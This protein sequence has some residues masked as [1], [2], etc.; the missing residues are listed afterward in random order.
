[1]NKVYIITWEG[2]DSESGFW[3]EYPCYGFGFFLTE[4]SVREK[5]KQL[6]K[7]EPG[8]YDEQAEETEKYKY[9][10]INKG[11]ENE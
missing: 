8:E 1:M 4:E 5:V 6:N 9:L 2:R 3:D 11:D 7:S 10:A